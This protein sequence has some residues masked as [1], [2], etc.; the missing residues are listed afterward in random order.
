MKIL[1]KDIAKQPFN[2]LWAFAVET[3]LYDARKH[4]LENVWQKTWDECIG[5]NSLNWEVS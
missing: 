1:K 2:D 5:M 4:L 3:I